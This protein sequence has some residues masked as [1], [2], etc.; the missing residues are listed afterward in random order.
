MTE[1]IY[2]VPPFDTMGLA[3]WPDAR[4][5]LNGLD[6][7]ENGFVINGQTLVLTNY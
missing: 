5:K 7:K 4:K 3:G 6:F 2:V 1:E